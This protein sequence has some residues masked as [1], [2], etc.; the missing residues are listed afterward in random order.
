[1]RPTDD[2]ECNYS[3]QAQECNIDDDFKVELFNLEA[4]RTRGL[5]AP[6]SLG[7]QVVTREQI[8]CLGFDKIKIHF[9]F[10][11]RQSLAG[12]ETC[13][14]HTPYVITTADGTKEDQIP[15]TVLDICNKYGPE[16]K[17]CFLYNYQV[18]LHVNG[19]VDIL[20]KMYSKITFKQM[21]G[22]VVL[23]G[24]QIKSAFKSSYTEQ[25]AVRIMPEI[26]DPAMPTPIKERYQFDG[27]VTRLPCD[28]RKVAD[29]IQCNDFY[30]YCT[31]AE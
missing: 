4:Q 3:N 8:Q 29:T 31:S 11:K 19:P 14:D 21:Q 15:Y 25:D 7:Y 12:A 20:P 9:E 26:Y 17:R 1:M 22:L 2:K 23:P 28:D 27:G 5:T 13:F 24:D 10:G 18:T 16:R 6:P 30:V